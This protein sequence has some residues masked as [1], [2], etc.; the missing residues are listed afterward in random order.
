MRYSLAVLVRYSTSTLRRAVAIL[1]VQISAFAAA[2]APAQGNAIASEYSVRLWRIEDGLPQ[3]RIRALCQTPDGYLWIGTDEGLARFDGIRFNIFDQSNTAALHDNGILTLKV[4][5]DGSLWIGTRGG[6]L[7]RYKD[8]LFRGFGVSDGL[9][10]GFVRTIYE[11]RLRILWVGTDRGFFR[12]EGE[13]FVRL[14]NTPEVPLASVVSIGEDDTGRIWAT[15]NAGLLSAGDKLLRVPSD[16]GAGPTN[17]LQQSSRGFLWVI[18]TMGAA[19]LKNGCMAV[20]PPLPAIRMTSLIEDHDGTL[21]IGTMGKG[22]MRAGSDGVTSLTA[23]SGLPDNAVNVVFE[24]RELN[25]WIGCQDGLV[26]LTKRSGRN[27]GAQDG[28][29][30]DNVST[31]YADPHDNLWFTTL[32]GQVYRVA[33]GVVQRYRLPAPAADLRVTTV[34]QERKGV[35][36]FG[37]SGSGLVLEEGNAATV[38]TKANGLRSNTVR[39]ILEDRSGILWIGLDSGLSRWDGHS[40]QNYYLPEGLSYPSVRSMIVE[41]Q[42]DLLVGTDAGLNRVHENRIV[43]DPEF[44]ALAKDRIWSI[45]QDSS[46]TL[47]LGTRGNGLIR[48]RRGKMVRFTKDK[49]LL[50]DTIQQI[51]EDGH[52]KLWMSTSSGVISADRKELNAAAESGTLPIHVI[53]YGTADGMATSQMNGGWQPAGARTSDGELWFPT[54]KGAV[55]INPAQIPPHHTAPI[56]IERVMVDDRAVSLAGNVVIPPGHGRLAIDYTLC[57]LVNPQRVGFRYKLEEF[58]ENWTPALQGRSAYYTNLPPGHYRFH[59]I[60]SDAASASVSEAFVALTLQPSF[61]QTTWFYALLALAAGTAVWGG[62]ALYA[63]QTRERYA[64]LLTERTRLAREM[65]DTV[66]QGCVG[67]STLLEAAARFRNVDTVEAETLLEQAR[68]EANTTLEEARQAVWNLRHPEGAE[69]SIDML[70]DL[71][72]KLGKEHGIPIETEMA[73]KRSLDPGTDRT[74]LLVGREALRNAVVHGKPENVSLRISFEPAEVSLTVTDNGSGFAADH[75]QA[76]ENRHFG[77]LGMRERVE[78]LGGAFSIVSEPGAGTRV[79]ARIP[80]AGVQP[81]DATT[82]QFPA[83]AR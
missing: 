26:R 33:N 19:R 81:S 14:D 74:I 13:R 22:L 70:F 65:H 83:G 29:E 80:L 55:R 25:L 32:T 38:F 27:I 4:G 48:Y 64:L 47:W 77:I 62:F 45:Y 73:G 8:G 75:E 18:G 3:N 72:R 35:M 52:G 59:V 36:W 78:K 49:G 24:D 12:R 20:E 67:V 69:S 31:V 40:F 42:G 10:N 63:R 68:I 76:A 9:T 11:D 57:D 5:A 61:Y 23:L 2:G 82:P 71:A 54:V 51:L 56:L 46:G 1:V 30:D 39:Q 21:W 17:I 44:A 53:P 6:G 58:D 41:A 34:F 28:L 15:S 16:C 37:T 66:I 60:A 7:A 79:V 50:T 43:A